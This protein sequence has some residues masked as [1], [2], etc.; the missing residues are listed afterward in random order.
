MVKGNGRG[1]GRGRASGNRQASNRG[2]G[3]RQ[4]FVPQSNAGPNRHGAT[5]EPASFSLRDEV[6]NTERSHLFNSTKKLRHSQVNFVSAGNSVPDELLNPTASPSTPPRETSPSPLPHASLASMTIEDNVQEGEHSHS[7]F[8]KLGESASAS[9]ETQDVHASERNGGQSKQGLFFMDGTGSQVKSKSK[10]NPP[11]LPRSVSPT[12]SSSSEEVIVFTGR[13]AVPRSVPE[14]NQNETGVQP[15]RNNHSRPQN[16]GMFA[17]RGAT[18]PSSLPTAKKIDGLQPQTQRSGKSLDPPKSPI[19]RS[20]DLDFTISSAQ[21]RRGWQKLPRRSR[22]QAAEHERLADYIAHMVDEDTPNEFSNGLGFSDDLAVNSSMM[23][24]SSSVIDTHTAEEAINTLLNPSS[25]WDSADL[26]DFDDLSTSTESYSVLDKVLASRQ[27]PTGQQ[28]LVVG[29]NQSIDEARWIPLSSL[30]SANARECIRV[31]ELTRADFQ[32]GAFSSDDSDDSIDDAQLSADLREELE[33]MED[34]RDLV[35]RR[36]ARMT[37]EKIARLLS[38]QEELGLGSNELVLFDGADED[39]EDEEDDLPAAYI[40]LKKA[41]AKKTR[42][43]HGDFVSAGLFAEELESDPYGDFDV[44]DHSRLSLRQKPKGRRGAPTFDL[45]DVELEASLQS[46][47]EKD[48]SKKKIRKK[49]REELRAQGLLGKS[50]HPD[51]NAKYKEGITLHQVREEIITF[52]HSD[53]Q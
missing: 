1:R 19:D 27:R 31:F 30:N 2:H 53:R 32:V 44:M 18:D 17:D 8:Q 33:S 13:R 42:K 20:Q 11:K 26:R 29:Q 38:K 41:R 35:E 3:A 52:M 43:P 50:G 21:S 7:D 34:E 9:L 39:D 22:S 37:D 10:L 51:L 28:Y 48:R 49:E 45:S 40:P 36:Q 47:W 46:A 12:P 24:T 15:Q 23:P 5:A 25:D 16:D 6:R 14:Q 4:H